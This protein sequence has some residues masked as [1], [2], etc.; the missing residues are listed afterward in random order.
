MF[1]YS[2]PVCEK[3]GRDIEYLS[4]QWIL[5]SLE[6][7]MQKFAEQNKRKNEHG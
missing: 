2:V 6:D 3:V 5:I 7:D 4:L 1:F